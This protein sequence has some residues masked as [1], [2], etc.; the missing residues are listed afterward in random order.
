M[1]N[2]GKVKVLDGQEYLDDALRARRVVEHGA[3]FILV[4]PR[5]GREMCS[6]GPKRQGTGPMRQ[7]VIMMQ[8]WVQSMTFSHMM[9][10]C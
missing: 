10:I 6:S 5:L 3:C 1:G 8:W 9:K 7:W 4:V 2:I